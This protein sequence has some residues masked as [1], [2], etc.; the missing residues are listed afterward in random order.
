MTKHNTMKTMETNIKS[1]LYHVKKESI[2][3]QK[4]ED[5][6]RRFMEF[7]NSKLQSWAITSNSLTFYRKLITYKIIIQINY[8]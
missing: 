6:Q 3:A 5:Y 7:F 4:P 1:A 8:F 2:S